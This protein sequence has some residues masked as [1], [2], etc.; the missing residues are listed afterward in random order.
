MKEKTMHTKPAQ[1]QASPPKATRR[2]RGRSKLPR[3]NSVVGNLSAEEQQEVADWVAQC[4]EGDRFGFASKQ[5]ALKGVQVS[6][7]GVARWYHHWWLQ[8]CVSSADS[9]ASAVQDALKALK[10]GLTEEQIDAAGQLIFTNR[11]LQ[12]QD[13]REFREMEYLRLAK[14]TAKVR[15]SQRERHLDIQERRL[16]DKVDVAIAAF[17]EEV[18]LRNDPELSALLEKLVAKIKE[19]KTL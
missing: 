4:K 10:L 11:A 17:V 2:P 6:A 8:Q 1:K 5:L 9:F 15:D 13:A 7:S 14:R 18:K 12:T 3:T 16:M 19:A